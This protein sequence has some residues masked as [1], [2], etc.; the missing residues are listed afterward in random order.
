MF[1][2]MKKAALAVTK[3]HN[4]NHQR[5][6][7]VDLLVARYCHCQWKG[8][9]WLHRASTLACLHML[10]IPVFYNL[11]LYSPIPKHTTFPLTPGPHVLDSFMIIDLWSTVS[12]LRLT[13]YQNIGFL[14]QWHVGAFTRE[15]YL[16]STGAGW[17]IWETAVSW[18]RILI[19]EQ[20][21]DIQYKLCTICFIISAK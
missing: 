8:L 12:I 16:L 19:K 6:S 17:C 1:H 11:L 13:G 14:L 15:H 4:H 5:L 18:K 9:P 3:Y 20:Q 21:R 7:W 10:Q 2:V